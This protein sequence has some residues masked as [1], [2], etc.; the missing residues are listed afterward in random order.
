MRTLQKGLIGLAAALT[1]AA[2]P[3]CSGGGSSV[4]STASDLDGNPQLQQLEQQ[5]VA[6]H[7]G[8]TPGV[9]ALVNSGDEIQTVKAGLG[10]LKNETPMSSDAVTRIASVSKAFSGAVALELVERDELALTSTIGTVLPDLPESWH[11]VTLMQLLQHTSGLPDYIADPVFLTEFVDDPQMRR[12]P[13][14]LLEYVESEPPLFTPGERYAYS[15]TDNIVV[16]LMVEAVTERPYTEVLTDLVLGP[17]DLPDTSLPADST[18]PKTAIRGYEPVEASPSPATEP[19][20]LDNPRA[21][22]DISELINPGLAWASGGMVGTAAQLDRFIRG[23][24]AGDGLS[25]ELVAAQRNVVPGDSGPPGPGANFS[26][27]G[28]YQY[29]TSCGT[30]FGH[31]GNM[32]GYTTFAA[33]VPDGEH[34]AVVI[35]NRQTNPRGSSARFEQFTEVMESAI[36]AATAN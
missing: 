33:S 21:W 14:Q 2:A 34:S 13:R 28:I 18:L 11:P 23:Y 10:N 27:L 4:D 6:L 9:L 32:P 16:G 30:F 12:T 20:A 29:E 31:T 17:R 25:A 19:P 26:G 1:L 3:A 15:D 22:E 8:G 36:C 7:E 24:A 35:L 5:V